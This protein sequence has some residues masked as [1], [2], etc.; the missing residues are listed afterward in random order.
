MNNLY[1]NTMAFL[2][3]YKNDERGV[4]AIE[5][6]LIAVAMAVLL[7]AVFSTQGSLIQALTKG[8]ALITAELTKMAP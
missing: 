4:T 3:T 6:G 1:A 5:Y 8:F 7:G 2:Y